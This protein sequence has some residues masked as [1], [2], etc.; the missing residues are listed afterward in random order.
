M[1]AQIKVEAYLSGR[2]K[3]R[4]RE[5]E[6]GPI[7]SNSRGNKRFPMEVIFQS[8]TVNKV[9]E[10]IDVRLKHT[11]REERLAR[12]KY[13][14]MKIRTKNQMTTTSQQRRFKR[15]IEE[16]SRKVSNK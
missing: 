11:K 9:I 8:R 10:I 5:R 13:T 1:G 15:L 16:I 6:V 7:P 3:G 2:I 4:H 12:Q 14:D